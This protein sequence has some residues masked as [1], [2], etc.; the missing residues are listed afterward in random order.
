MNQ[1][2]YARLVLVGLA[3]ST[4][5]LFGIAGLWTASRRL[6]WFGR[7]APP[8]VL[9]AALLPAG[10]FELL[11]LL[12]AQVVVVLGVVL[13]VGVVRRRRTGQ[14]VSGIPP[15]DLTAAASKVGGRRYNFA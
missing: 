15:V 13:V 2:F 11:P 6:G 9:L 14:K 7:F 8:V 3:V 5:T 4:V 1:V 12:A 10:L